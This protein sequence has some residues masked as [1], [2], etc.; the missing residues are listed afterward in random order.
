M[1]PHLS[2]TS[3]PVDFPQPEALRLADEL[4]AT[5]EGDP[6]AAELRR[7]HAAHEHQ[8]NMAGLMLREA[9]RASRERDMLVEALKDVTVSLIAAHSLLQEGGKQAAPSDTMFEI[10][11]KDYEK[12]IE[13]GRN[14]IRK[15]R[16]SDES[17]Q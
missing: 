12:S 10:M 11:L 5:W 1:K 17:D 2:N 8:Y 16:N 4:E 13:V 15:F 3:N 7:L 6:A 14:A 9:E